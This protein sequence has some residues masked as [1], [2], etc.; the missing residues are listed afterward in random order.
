MSPSVQFYIQ[1]C[2]LTCHM[3]MGIYD[4]CEKYYYKKKSLSII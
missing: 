4:L 2:S 3:R 1:K